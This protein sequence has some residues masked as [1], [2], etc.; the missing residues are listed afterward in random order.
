MTSALNLSMEGNG[1]V[2]LRSPFWLLPFGSDKGTLEHSCPPPLLYLLLS[3]RCG[4][5]YKVRDFGY[6]CSLAD[7]TETR[8]WLPGTDLSTG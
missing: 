3:K 7:G 4:A 5:Q 1:P 8:N 6:H 2:R